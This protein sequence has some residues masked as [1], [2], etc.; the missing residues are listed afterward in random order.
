MES[1][2]DLQFYLC[3][4]YQ[5]E[6]FF[7]ESVLKN[8]AKFAKS[9]VKHLRRSLLSSNF[10]IQETPGLLFSGES[11]EVFKNTYFVEHLRTA[12]S[13]HHTTFF[14]SLTI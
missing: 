13:G 12:A 14:T 10:V 3:L 9:T 6:I 5:Q 7:K 8:F 4:R 11:Y 1:E 2:L